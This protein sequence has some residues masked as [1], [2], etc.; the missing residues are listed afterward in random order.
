MGDS[1]GDNFG[2]RLKDFWEWDG[3]TAS[4]A[5]NTWTRKADFPG[6]GRKAPIAFT[7]GRKAYIGLGADDSADVWHTDFW[8]WDG[9]TG[10]AKYNTWTRKADF[11]GVARQ[12][13]TGF[14]IGAKG[15][16][17]TGSASIDKKD[18]WEWDQATDTWTQKIDLAGDVRWIAS[19]LSIGNK[20]YIGMGYGNGYLMDFWEY[21]DT[22]SGVGIED[23]KSNTAGFI[24]YPN[25]A[26]DKIY[27][28]LTKN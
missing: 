15:Y 14:S 13:A 17:G 1:A 4:P 22:C 5:Y 12:E 11:P 3:D 20:G 2:V 25:P 6:I 21:C 23:F 26:K 28:Q 8:E 19:G 16:I 10:S 9:D 27:I 24:V 18:F 7:I